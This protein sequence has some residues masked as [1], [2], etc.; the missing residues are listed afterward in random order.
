MT[1]TLAHGRRPRSG[2]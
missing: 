1:A 2:D